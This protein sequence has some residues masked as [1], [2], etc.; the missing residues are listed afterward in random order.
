MSLSFRKYTG[1]NWNTCMVLTTWFPVPVMVENRVNEVKINGTNP[2]NL[3]E[4]SCME[5]QGCWRL[6][7]FLGYYLKSV[8]Y[9]S[10][11]FFHHC[12]NGII[13]RGPIN[14]TCA[15]CSTKRVYFVNLIIFTRFRD[16][17]NLV[18]YCMQLHHEYW[19]KLREILIFLIKKWFINFELQ[20]SNRIFFAKNNFPMSASCIF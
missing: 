3:G 16:I 14:S 18:W 8:L 6:R 7:N 15:L 9:I 13:T 11:N 19:R 20:F 12:S 10:I 5:D 1:W 17:W 4:C 2:T